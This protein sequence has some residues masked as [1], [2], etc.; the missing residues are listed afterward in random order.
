MVKHIL[1][2]ATIVFLLGSFSPLAA[3]KSKQGKTR[4]ARTD[5]KFLEDIS[6]QAST[7][8]ASGPKAV[9][10]ESIFTTPAPVAEPVSATSI[11]NASSLQIKYAQLMNI[12]VE[13]I[14]NI[15][16]FK[17][18]DEWLGTKYRLGGTT[19]DGIDC[20]AFMQVLFTSLYGI[21]LP[22][23]AREQYGFARAVSRSEIRQGDLIF[24]N[25]I[26]GISHVGMYLQNNKFVHASSGGVTISDLYEDYW[27]KHFVG[28]GRVDSTR[29]ATALSSNP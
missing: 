2:A 19:K 23:T 10:A 22:R 5:V 7:P 8:S 3:Q 29:Q 11:E 1:F 14:Q 25:T 9:F 24:F 21:A 18:I 26:G 4:T 12:E 15:S 27:L 16:L 17:L 20:S 13:M 28:V 6:V